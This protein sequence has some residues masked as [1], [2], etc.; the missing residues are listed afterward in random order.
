MGR[1]VTVKG[2][3]APLTNGQ[4]QWIFN[5]TSPANAT[6]T[7]TNST[8]QT[9][10]T[11]TGTVQPGTQNF[12]WS[13]RDNNGQQLP[14]GNYTLTITAAGTNGQSVA[15]PTTVTGVVDSADLT[16]NPPTLSIGGQS[17]TLNQILS[18]TQPLGSSGNAL[19]SLGSSVA[20]TL[21][22]LF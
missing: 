15:I 22:N 4:A 6:F 10:F 13:G 9:V 19:S 11:Q 2:D 7:I 18:V 3:T 5:P 8:G 21:G 20:S 14:D 16:Q 1:T 17:F 12:N